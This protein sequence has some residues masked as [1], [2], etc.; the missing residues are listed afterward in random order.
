MGLHFGCWLLLV[1]VV[2][3]TWDP[4]VFAVKDRELLSWCISNA[5][6]VVTAL[7]RKAVSWRPHHVSW[8]S[9]GVA[10]FPNANDSRN[11]VVFS[12]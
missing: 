10:E 12:Y 11:S 6:I 8:L 3:L 1:I 9:N 4:N 2:E 7:A 5:A